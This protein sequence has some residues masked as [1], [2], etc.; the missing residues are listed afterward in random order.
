MAMAT[1]LLPSVIML[2]A[3]TSCAKHA[4]IQTTP[5][6][7]GG[8]I[9]FTTT[10]S[11][12][13]SG[14]WSPD[15]EWIAFE[16]EHG[17][18]T[19]IWVQPV[20][21]G[22]AFQIT[23]DEAADRVPRWSP[24]GD[25]LLFV[26]ERS[27]ARAI[28]TIDPFDSTAVST[29]VTT[30]DDELAGLIANWSHDGKEIVFSSNRT[31]NWDLWTVAATGGQARQITDRPDNDWDPDWSQDGAW[32]VF[33]SNQTGAGGNL[34]VVRAA[35]GQVRQLT[36]GAHGDYQPAFSPNGEW[37][38]FNSP[39]CHRGPVYRGGPPTAEIS[40][41]PVAERALAT[42]SRSRVTGPI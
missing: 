12:E 30:D 13:G 1:S 38:A 27:G 3:M 39:Q 31:G 23:D 9:Q 24:N 42:S 8:D 22:V 14:D 36:N 20:A 35:G 26:S 19:D 7:A 4:V 37:I 6:R 11:D 18:N 32:I 17:G 16:S 29:Q 5:G 21:G 33:N 15:G 40:C 25:R 2:L 41:S 10:E 34:F 28:W